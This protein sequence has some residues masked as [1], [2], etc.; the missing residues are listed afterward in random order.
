RSICHNLGLDHSAVW[1]FAEGSDDSLLLTH[2]PEASQPDDLALPHSA[3]LCD[4]D[5]LA[6]L[7]LSMEAKT[8][9]PWTFLQLRQG[10]NVA[11]AS[12]AELPPEA[13]LDREML[14]REGIK[15]LLAL[16]LRTGPKCL[17]TLTFTTTA[18]ERNWTETDVRRLRLV[19]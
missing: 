5:Q 18:E 4:C 6:A 15:S 8:F 9:F 7:P 3:S 19:G 1:Q 12:L 10:H 2:S 17:G 11:L 13:V 16:P 14:M